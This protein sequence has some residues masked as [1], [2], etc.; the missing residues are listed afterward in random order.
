MASKGGKLNPLYDMAEAQKY[1]KVVAK[2]AK[3]V[4]KTNDKSLSS[5]FY[6]K[7]VQKKKA[8]KAL[9]VKAAGDA[10]R[11]IAEAL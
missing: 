9:E 1:A 3:A 8:E 11:N 10:V 7:T 5:L 2:R 6:F 4:E